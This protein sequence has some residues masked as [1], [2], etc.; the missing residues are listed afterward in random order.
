MA[1]T[2]IAP[3]ARESTEE[4]VKCFRHAGEDCPRCDGLGFR[5]RVYCAEC[6]EP[7]GRISEG[8]KP[9]VGLRNRR[10]RNQPMY[11]LPC[12]PELNVGGVPVLGR[13]GD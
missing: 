7:A 4:F 8:G 2:T 13:M 10:E 11:C 3:S 9:L 6:G 1:E 12:H 5:P